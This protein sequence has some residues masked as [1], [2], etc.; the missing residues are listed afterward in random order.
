M[1]TPRTTR[2]LP[3]FTFLVS[4]FGASVY[5]FFSS[6][7]TAGTVDSSSLVSFPFY[8]LWGDSPVI[9]WSLAVLFSGTTVLGF[10]LPM[11]AASPIT[12]AT[13]SDTALTLSDVSSGVSVW[14]FLLVMG[15]V[16]FDC[17]IL[18]N[19]GF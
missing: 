15:I 18:A 8:Y 11:S 14:W 6:V 17:S 12:L 5:T 10:Y 2:A 16:G 7:P 9:L 13:A 1:V 3:S 4:Y 19:S